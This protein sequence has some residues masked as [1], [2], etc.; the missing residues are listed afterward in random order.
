MS[1]EKVKVIVEV[2]GGLVQAVY[3]GN[4]VQVVIVDHDSANT[5][6]MPVEPLQSF[7]VADQKSYDGGFPDD[8]E[9]A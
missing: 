7:H 1:Q 5:Q 8:W 6:E 4:F 2:N 3:A 9:A